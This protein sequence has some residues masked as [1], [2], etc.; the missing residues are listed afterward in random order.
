LEGVYSGTLVRFYSSV[1]LAVITHTAL[2]LVVPL[3]MYSL[4]ASQIEIGLASAVYWAV[5]IPLQPV[6]GRLTSKR[7]QRLILLIGTFGLAV[8][9][10]IFPFTKSTVSFIAIRF[11]QGVFVSAFWPATRSLAAEEAPPLKTGEV[12]GLYG[13]A[14][15]LSGIIGPFL[16]GFVIDSSGFLAAFLLPVLSSTIALFPLLIG[17]KSRSR[18]KN[19]GI[20]NAIVQNG[21]TPKM[22]L[23][24]ERMIL[25]VTC[26]AL[27]VQGLTWGALNSVF[28]V[29]L[30]I[31]QFKSTEIGIIIMAQSVTQL[32]FQWLGGRFSDK[33]NRPLLATLGVTFTLSIGAIALTTSFLGF[34]LIMLAVGLGVGILY[35]AGLTLISELP[36]KK[37]GLAFGVFGSAA[38]TGMA[39]GSQGGGALAQYISLTAPYIVAFVIIASISL[40]LLILHRR[41]NGIRNSAETP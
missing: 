21:M 3:Y 14:M 20:E 6:F 26:L 31:L 29:Y 17:W 27:F 4:G 25:V 36:R 41:V 1:F 18:S 24:Y 19:Q 22:I 34:I 16:G 12:M 30:R 10:L 5:Q 9:S 8:T 35:P 40:V 15:S 32:V 37:K 28:P 11:T 33:F 38:T 23:K 39:L 7:R 13:V 2:Y